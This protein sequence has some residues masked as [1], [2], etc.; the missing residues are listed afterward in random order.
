MRV[1]IVRHL[2]RIEVS[3]WATIC[4]LLEID[5]RIIDYS[6]LKEHYKIPIILDTSAPCS[7]DIMNFKG[8]FC[9]QT[10]SFLKDSE[11]PIH[12]IDVV[13][14]NPLFKNIY[15]RDKLSITPT[16]KYIDPDC[17]QEVLA[18][19]RYQPIIVSN[20]S[21]ILSSFSIGKT[22]ASKD[23]DKDY[24]V[25]LYFAQNLVEHVLKKEITEV[26]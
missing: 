1:D 4:S 2:N 5:Y 14:R 26:R 13:S 24:Y 11:I 22:L 21:T 18:D 3:Q 9:L 23:I 10:H 25:F 6:N 8:I 12:N 17:C 15:F 16:T 7:L 20:E 19:C